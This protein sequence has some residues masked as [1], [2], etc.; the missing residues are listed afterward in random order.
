MND[1]TANMYGG[2]I[3]PQR[4]TF[5]N[6][7]FSMSDT[8]KGE[9]L[10][11]IQYSIMG[12]I[13][14]VL[15][16]KLIQK[17]SPDVDLDRSSLEIVLE[18]VGQLIVMFCGV[19]FIHRMITFIPTYSEYKY[20]ELNL[21]SVILAFLILIL[22]IQTKLGLKVN[23]LVER[24]SELW[25]GPKQEYKKKRKQYQEELQTDTIIP[26]HIMQEQTQTQPVH[27]QQQQ[28]MQQEQPQSQPVAANN[29]FGGFGSLF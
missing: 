24:L 11:V 28:Q 10:N 4:Q 7:V 13:P 25:N 21:T 3:T 19:I 8:S 12:I 6:H 1:G 26:Q 15:L 18:I 20:E 22:S 29:I 23:I 2:A 17:M 27:R 14:V 5:F 16:N 9:I